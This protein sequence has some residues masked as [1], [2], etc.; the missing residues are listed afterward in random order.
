MLADD[1]KRLKEQK[2]LTTQQLADLSGLPASTISRILSGQTDSPGF[3]NVCD[4]VGAMGG[5]LDE[6]AGFS[7][8][9]EPAEEN[10]LVELY[11]KTISEK[12]RWI[13]WLFIANCVFAGAFIVLLLIDIL[14]GGIGFI[15]Y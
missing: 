15:R 12:N 1:L 10:A 11:E 8:K 7:N 6:L 9:K 13:R 5:S 4:L 14:N 2:N 3:Q